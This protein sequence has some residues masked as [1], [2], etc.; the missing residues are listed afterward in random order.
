MTKQQRIIDEFFQLVS[1][2][3]PTL[4]EAK[5]SEVLKKKLQ[6][7]GFSEIIEDDVSKVIGGT[8][9][10]I[11]AFMAG[12]AKNAHDLPTIML[13]AHM[14]CVNP[15]LG[16][17]PQLVDG[18]ISSCG[19]TVLG[20][21]DKAGIVAILEGIRRLKEDNIPFANVQVIFSVA[22]EGGIYGTKHM[23]KSKIKADFGY[24]LDAGGTPGVIVYAAPGSYKFHIKVMGRAAHAGIAPEDGISAIMVAAKALQ[25]FPQG[26]VDEQSTANVGSIKG[27]HATNIVPDLVEITCEVRSLDRETLE[28]LSKQIIYIFEKATDKTG[29]TV[30]ITIDKCYEAFKLEQDMPAILLAKNAANAM[31]LKV[32]VEPTGGGSD[33]NHFNA[34]GLPTVPL[35]TGMSKVH[36]TDEYIAVEHL[37]QLTELVGNILKCG[38]E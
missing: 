31:G 12:S 35:G 23:D 15:C 37:E 18:I 6:E 32:S 24:V 29:A 17:K 1:I 3:S 28:N 2:D 22:E 34:Y 8:A 9:N 14:D 25:N 36:T 27:G 5:I 21:D 7:L 33:A 19:D 16:V 13:S 38:A 26:R 10:N 11:F 20:S 4:G 30:D